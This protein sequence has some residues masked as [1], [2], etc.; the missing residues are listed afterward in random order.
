MLD[1]QIGID[2]IEVLGSLG[3]VLAMGKVL[4]HDFNTLSMS[5]SFF[6]GK[7]RSGCQLLLR[8]FAL[9]WTSER[10]STIHK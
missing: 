6:V 9:F 3:L 5:G 7:C 2:F 1:A 4:I 10:E 8:C